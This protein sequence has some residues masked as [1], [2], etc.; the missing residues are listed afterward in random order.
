MIKHSLNARIGHRWVERRRR[1]GC[2]ESILDG[3]RHIVACVGWI[4]ERDDV[5]LRVLQPVL[6]F[7][8]HL[9]STDDLDEPQLDGERYQGDDK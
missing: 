1:R 5:G 3:I 4:A 9:G 7:Q 6:F 8:V 2:V